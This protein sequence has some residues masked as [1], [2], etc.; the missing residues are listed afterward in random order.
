[1]GRVNNGRIS[2][3]LLVALAGAGAPSVAPAHVGRTKQ[4]E[5]V[6]DADPVR[7]AVTVS[8]L[9]AAVA[10]GLGADAKPAALIE[11]AGP[12][13]ERWRQRL[14]LSSRGAQC[15]ASAGR[16]S[17]A[18][19]A[20]RFE[21]TYRCPSMVGIQFV[22]LDLSDA[23][24]H[25]TRL[26][27][28]TGPTRALKVLHTDAPVLLVPP[29]WTTTAVDFVAEGA[30]HLV[31]GYD[32][33]LFLMTL[34][35]G[36]AWGARRFGRWGA[37]RRTATI[38]TAF[39]VGHSVTLALSVYE[40]VNLPVGPVEATIALSIVLAAAIN[41]ASPETAH[42]RPLIALG[43]GLIHGVG[44]S[45]VLAEVGLPPGQRALALLSFNFGIEVAQLLLVAVVLFPLLGLAQRGWYRPVIA[46]GGSGL[47]AVLGLIWFAE[48]T[49]LL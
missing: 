7:V 44:F 47:A 2:L 36:A 3:T 15:T 19:E 17:L 29:S 25:E 26:V 42:A 35:V 1:M 30:L 34:L 48:R 28:G 18:S 23:S 10:L 46:T 6:T 31:T 16:A 39:T 38:V 33:L 43:F 11:G 32:H 49:S 9:E 45:S 27:I 37:L 4:V 5:V 20:L 13:A 22:D 24:G 14:V 40:H 12:L 21:Y 41:M 8:A